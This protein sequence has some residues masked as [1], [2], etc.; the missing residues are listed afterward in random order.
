MIVISRDCKR[1]SLEERGSSTS[2]EIK[3]VIHGFGPK[4]D[5]NSYASLSVRESRHL[6]LSLLQMS[7]EME[8]SSDKAK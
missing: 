6:A 7:E 4:R 1:I 8:A 2:P 3:L 5:R